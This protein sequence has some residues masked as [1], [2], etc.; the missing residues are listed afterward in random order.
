MTCEDVSNPAALVDVN[1]RFLLFQRVQPLSGPALR[2]DWFGT[3]DVVGLVYFRA[4]VM[5]VAIYSTN[6][7]ST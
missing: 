5:N 7:S 6:A 2:V 4:A 3:D 1:R